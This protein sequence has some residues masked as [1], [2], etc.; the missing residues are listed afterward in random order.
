MVERSLSEKLLHDLFPR[1][2]SRGDTGYAHFGVMF[3]AWDI[4]HGSVRLTAYGDQAWS[5]DPPN[6]KR[7]VTYNLKTHKVSFE[8]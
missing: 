2:K 3:E 4:P 7:R 5:Q 6:F 8:D 1:F